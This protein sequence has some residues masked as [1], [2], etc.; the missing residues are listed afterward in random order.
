MLLWGTA[1]RAAAWCGARR[2]RQL[3]SLTVLD[4]AAAARSSSRLMAAS[5]FVI[6]H[7]RYIV[8]APMSLTPAH[9]PAPKPGPA[10]LANESAPLVKQA[11]RRI[12]R[13]IPAL[14][15]FRLF[16]AIHIVGVHFG[17]GG[18]LTTNSWR[19]WG[20]C[21]VP[22]FFLLSGFGVAHSAA[23]RGSQA[24]DNAELLPRRAT[25]LRRL[26]KVYPTYLVC[27]L[28]AT[29][30]VPMVLHA[31]SRGEASAGNPLYAPELSHSELV[32]HYV[33]AFIEPFMVQAYAPATFSAARFVNSP[34]W[35]VSAITFCWLTEPVILRVCSYC[36]TRL[37]GALSVA[38][39]MVWVVVWPPVCFPF[40]WG[41]SPLVTGEAPGPLYTCASFR[42]GFRHF[43]AIS[44]LMFVHQ[45][46][47]GVLLALV[48][49]ARAADVRTTPLRWGACVA[50]LVLLGTFFIHPSWIGIPV[51]GAGSDFMLIWVKTVGVLLP[52]HC[53][54]IAGLVEGDPI[55]ALGQAL[56]RAMAFSRDISLS[57][58]LVQW[59]V[60]LWFTALV[61]SAQGH[62]VALTYAQFVGLLACIVTSG[63]IVTYGVQLPAERLLGRYLAKPKAEDA[64]KASRDP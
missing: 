62:Q 60:G 6:N 16:A 58:Y 44:A 14:D 38:L 64:A 12:P 42:S 40:T 57:I 47:C 15:G 26:L 18:Y 46:A 49:H 27:F 2:D 25:L 53:L 11:G 32:R 37:G 35:W 28:L 9:A 59:P 54:L 21:W 29:T 17:P 50:C 48:L 19:V 61:S 39:L 55:A 24:P 52:V 1:R 23:S 45:Y 63:S 33:F 10:P 34:D 36:F 22:F 41:C 3:W 43:Y 30:R 8:V 20:H 7:R 56:P 5:F 51:D 31:L 4:M 13:E